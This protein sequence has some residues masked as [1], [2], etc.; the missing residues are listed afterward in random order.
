[1]CFITYLPASNPDAAQGLVV[2][3]NKHILRKKLATTAKD[4]QINSWQELM[5]QT[6]Q[7]SFEK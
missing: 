6:L 5:A 4:F 1:V 7:Q 3:S 2:A